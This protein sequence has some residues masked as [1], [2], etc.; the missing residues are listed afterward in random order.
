MRYLGVLRA[1]VA[2]TLLLLA[3]AAVA[4]AGA[5]EVSYWP[6]T[7]SV[8]KASYLPG[9]RV[10]FT[11]V[12]ENATRELLEKLEFDVLITLPTGDRWIHI[13]YP[14]D[15]GRTILG[16]RLEFDARL[17]GD[18]IVV[19]FSLAFEESGTYTAKLSFP[20]YIEELAGVPALQLEFTVRPTYEIV[21]VVVD[22]E[23]R[24]VEGARVVVLETGEEAMTDEAGRFSVAVPAP[25]TYTLRAEAVNFLPAVKEVSVVAVGTTDAGTIQ[26]ESV[27]HAIETL[28]QEVAQVR[29]ELS[30]VA[31]EHAARIEELARRLDELGSR[32]QALEEALSELAGRADELAGRVD[33]LTGA[34]EELRAAV[35]ELRAELGDLAGELGAAVEALRGDLEELAR[36][37][38]G[39]EANYATRDELRGVESRLGARVDEL[40]ARLGELEASLTERIEGLAQR[41]DNLEQATIQQLSTDIRQLTDRMGEL[42]GRIEGISMIAFVAVALAVVGIA[43]A[44]V[45][46]ILVYRKIAA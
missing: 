44:L 37:L 6:V 32:V 26:L 15:E 30:R 24:P 17:V 36:R 22:E 12:I 28:R 34:L 19:T 27:V 13:S 1:A 31:E 40:S 7:F 21:G 3:V 14:A 39:V 25:G 8:D 9:E 43:V 23:G 4:A 33:E 2:S 11:V 46:T 20:Y 41:L 29:S 45:A 18:R 16:Q 10:T 38:A 35:G 42:A 5:V